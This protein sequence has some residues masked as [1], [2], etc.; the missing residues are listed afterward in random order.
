MPGHPL[1]LV[2]ADLYFEGRAILF[3]F[4]AH[5]RSKFAN[6]FVARTI[7]RLHYVR[8][9]GASSFH[10]A[11]IGFPRSIS[12]I[13][14]SDSYQMWASI[15]SCAT[16]V[17]SM[18]IHCL[19][20]FVWCRKSYIIRN[21]AVNVFIYDIRTQRIFFYKS[22]LREKIMILFFRYVL[23]KRERKAGYNL[24][25]SNYLNTILFIYYFT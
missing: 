8:L 19:L 10:R 13:S 16:K 2:C 24:Y 25:K 5:F 17:L 23:K 6:F 11:R 21:T 7:T 9:R 4:T 1:K 18:R 12:N 3:F 20:V 22:V 14:Y 15:K